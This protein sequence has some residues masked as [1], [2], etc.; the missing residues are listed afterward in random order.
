[1]SGQVI[2]IVEMKEWSIPNENEQETGVNIYDQLSIRNEIINGFISPSA[3]Q[4]DNF[5]SWCD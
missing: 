2:M 1:M 3:T 5:P 4:E